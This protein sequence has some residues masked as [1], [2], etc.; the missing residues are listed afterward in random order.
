MPSE[1]S[2][3]LLKNHQIFEHQ[4]VSKHRVNT[5]ISI[6]FADKAVKDTHNKERL[7]H[8]VKRHEYRSWEKGKDQSALNVDIIILILQQK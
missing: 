4:H 3:K 1:V 8:T 6:S 5:V 7:D 2:K